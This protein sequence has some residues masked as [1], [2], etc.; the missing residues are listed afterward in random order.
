MQARAFWAMVRCR[1]DSHRFSFCILPFIN[2]RMEHCNWVCAYFSLYD[3]LT[4]QKS[5]KHPGG[6]TTE[7]CF[8]C[9]G[10]APCASDQ[11]LGLKWI[12]MQL[13]A[14]SSDAGTSGTDEQRR[15][16]IV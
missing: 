11:R 15:P 13:L 9:S 16:T 2:H 4:I 14:S 10:H 1:L 5:G 8:R 12:C 6:R 3:A 7:H